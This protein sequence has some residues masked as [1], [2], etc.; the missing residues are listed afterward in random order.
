MGLSEHDFPW[1]CFDDFKHTNRPSWSL[2]FCKLKTGLWMML[3]CFLTTATKWRCLVAD[4][5]N[6]RSVLWL[7]MG[8]W[9]VDLS[10]AEVLSH[11]SSDIIAVLFFMLCDIIAVLHFFP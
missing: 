5:N 11:S 4:D 10:S 9:L 1:N 3:E 6:G 8:V 7:V 2:F